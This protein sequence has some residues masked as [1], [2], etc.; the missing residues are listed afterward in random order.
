MIQG[1]N[2]NSQSGIRTGFVDTCRWLRLDNVEL[3]TNGDIEVFM[4]EKW[5]VLI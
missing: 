1:G 5:A 2:R 3:N 4:Y